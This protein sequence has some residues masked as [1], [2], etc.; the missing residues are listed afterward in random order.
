VICGLSLVISDDFELL[1]T[2]AGRQGM[3]ISVTVCLCV[4]FCNFVRLR[5]SPPRSED[6]ATGVILLHEVKRILSHK[7]CPSNV[8]DNLPTPDNNSTRCSDDADIL[9]R[10]SSLV[11]QINTCLV[12]L[13]EVT[14]CS[15]I[16]TVAF[17]L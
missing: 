5:I 17:L 14:S 16:H 11:S 15:K 7:V 12:L 6:K 9:S 2:H 10:R 3:D 4:Y 13:R 1:F 8:V